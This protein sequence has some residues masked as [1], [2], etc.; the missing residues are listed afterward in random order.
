MKKIIYSLSLLSVMFG[1]KT[2][3]KLSTITPQPVVVKMDLVNVV[4]DQVK[5]TVDP[6]KF[7]EDQTTFYIPKTVPG[8]YS[9]DNYGEFIENL[10]AYDYL[11][12]E[13]LV[14]KTDENSWLI[15]N[16]TQLDKVT[17]YVNDSFDMEGEK[18]V[19]S[20]SGTNIDKDKNFMLNLHGLV[21]YFKNLTEQPYELL[22]KR[23]EGLTPG[24]SLMAANSSPDKVSPKTM[25][26]LFK[27]SRYFEIT[28]QPIM[29]AKPDTAYINIK[30]MRVLLD[31]YSPNGVHS[32]KEIKPEIEK[33]VTA[34][35][36]FL[37]DIDKTANYAII[38]YLADPNLLDAKGYGAL[39]H[40]T[41]TVVVLPETMPLDK[42]NQSMT[43]VVS[44]EFFHI[45]TPLS[46][47]SNE[48]HYFDYNDPKMSEH[49]WMYEGVT[50]Y[51]ANLF[52]INQDLIS[53]DEF[54]GRISEK[55]ESSKNFNDTIPFTVMSRHILEEPYKND[56]YNVYQKG[57]LIGMSLDIKLRELS[58]GKTGILDLMSKLSQKYG[59]DAPFKDEELIPTI[60]S[61]TYPEIQDF[62]D[63]YVTGTTPIPYEEFLEIVGLEFSEQEIETSFFINGRV[64]YID[65]NP[66]N[67]SLFFRKGIKLNSF[68]KELGV[69]NGDVIK[70]VNGA[71]YNIQNAYDLVMASQN[72][73]EGEN[74]TMVVERDG[75]EISFQGKIFTPKDMKVTLGAKELPADSKAVMLR[76][77]WLKG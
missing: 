62:F 5:V 57:A 11:G 6:G 71:S 76:K 47:H 13:L 41:S 50:E 15:D 28:D 69:E 29:Y 67:M 27:A 21:G 64:P 23:P 3:Q 72:W 65:G 20:P 53:N 55:I 16:A 30:G 24:T 19:F 9:I 51:F 63:T 74:F 77:A 25:V 38:L 22:I 52:Q 37:G 2:S 48:I 7:T 33:M 39:E 40:H 12:N 14:A 68:F 75:K 54:Y 43:D 61:L 32:A 42:L 73:K 18:G 10:K 45:L 58:D 26:D 4:D 31:V 49:L 46:V 17:Y 56:Y 66:E 59:K 60:V 36:N 35:K 1:C 8:T 44:H 34:Q 70:T